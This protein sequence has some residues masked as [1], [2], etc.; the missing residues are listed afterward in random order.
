MAHMRQMTQAQQQ[1]MMQQYMPMPQGADGSNPA[2][3]G[4]NGQQPAYY[5]QQPVYLD[6]N[7]QPVYYRVANQNGQYQQQDGQMMYGVPGQEGGQPGENGQAYNPYNPAQ[8]Q[9]MGAQGG[10]WAPQGQGE[11]IIHCIVVILI[12]MRDILFKNRFKFVS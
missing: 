4:A 9:A 10:Y 7:G 1:Q 5:V 12:L 3:G 6:Q 8:A 2:A 11:Q